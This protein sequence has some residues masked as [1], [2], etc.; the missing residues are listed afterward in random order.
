[1]TLEEA[2]AEWGAE[3]LEVHADRNL[4]TLQ[5][6]WRK[7]F[8]PGV[9]GKSL[10]FYWHVF[11][12]RSTPHL[13]GANAVASYEARLAWHSAFVV[14]ELM[15]GPALLCRFDLAPTYLRL[16]N[17]WSKELYLVEAGMAWSFVLTHEQDYGPY[18]VERAPEPET[19]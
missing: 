7:A 15:R 10:Q 13:E 4:W 16:R 17:G 14:E 9:S 12:G 2:L 11:S 19:Y 5:R 3:I 1:M 18:F 8:A 6:E